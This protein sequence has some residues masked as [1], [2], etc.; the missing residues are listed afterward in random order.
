MG[1]DPAQSPRTEEE[2]STFALLSVGV[3][4]ACAQRKVHKGLP[5]AVRTHY[6]RKWY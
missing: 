5:A 4:S 3:S 2:R 1:G 6:L